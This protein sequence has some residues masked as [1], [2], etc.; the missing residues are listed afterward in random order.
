MD[1]V[2]VAVIWVHI[3]WP[4]AGEGGRNEETTS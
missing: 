3:K 2:V 1:G 4:K